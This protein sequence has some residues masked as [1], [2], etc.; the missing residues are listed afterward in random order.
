MERQSEAFDKDSALDPMVLYDS[1]EGVYKLWY[2][3]D[4][5]CDSRSL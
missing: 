5:D 4:T 3:G 2:V 1:D